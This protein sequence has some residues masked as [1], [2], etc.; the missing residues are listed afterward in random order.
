M[1]HII[2]FFVLII[3]CFPSLSTAS[4]FYVRDGGG[5]LY[6]ASQDPTGKCNGLTN[7]VYPGS[8]VN[9]NCA[10][11]NPDYVLGLGCDNF[12]TITNCTYGPKIAS[13][14][15]VFI[16]GDSDV[17]PGTQA[18]Y[19]IGW[20][21][22]STDFFN[23]NY[24]NCKSAYSYSCTM[25]NLP[26]GTSGAPTS[27]IGTGTHQ[28]QLYALNTPYQ[29]LNADNNF[30]TLQNLEI[31]DH[32]ACAYNDPTGSCSRYWD[33]IWLGGDSLIL[34]NIYAHG[35]SRY[36]IVTDNMG[37]ATF[38]NLWVIGNGYG[39]MTIGNGGTTS[40]SG[41]L[42]FNQP[43]VEWNGCV[44]A[45]PV[46]GGIDNPSNYT[47]CFGQTSGG[48]GDGLAFGP[49]GN[50]NAGNWTITGPGSISFN[51]QDGLDTLHG[52]GNGTIQVDKMRFEGNAGNQVK[53]NA[54]NES[55]TNSLV[56]GDCGWWFG[57]PQS[58]SGGMQS[59]DSCRALGDVFLFNVTN[60]SV[61]NIF[62]NT[63]MSNGNISLESKDEG[64]TGCNSNTTITAKN[65][66]VLGGYAWWDDTTWNGSGGNSFTTYIY[67][68]G[69]NGDG[70]G[71]CGGLTWNE[72]YNVVSWSAPQCVGSHD[73][74]NT[75]PGFTGTIPIG[76]SGGGASTYYQGQGAV[77]QVPITNSSAAK[78]AGVSGLSYWNN[79]NDYY[80]VTR[81]SPPSI[82][83]L[84]YASC[85]VNTFSPCFFN[86]DCCIGTCTN[87]VCA[88]A[89]PGVSEYSLISG[90]SLISGN[91]NF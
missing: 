21:P 49:S 24:G 1:W 58:L 13:G 80:N 6:N 57:A 77:T 7:A 25:A 84:E 91:S 15:T 78:G 65:N 82:G 47:N 62:N 52:A 17:N 76:T 29:V 8:G 61:T 31:T 37:S 86:T 10:V 5:D 90:K 85:A 19:P 41:T 14:D 2:S 56:I 73:K 46:T 63:F 72:D 40:I 79:S 12:G 32:T 34:T 16:S 4:V 45:Y 11:S 39:G 81:P 53:M 87:N 83:G 33:G 69:N 89:S 36:G 23:G 71:T 59:G 67:N 27:I 88:G 68:A 75:S 44:E 18:Q 3:T 22:S 38:T 55:L 50:Q 9:Q 28:P 43:I 64:S 70:G 35:L 54:I 26:A 51:T 74:C 48:Y 60:N 30:I 66:I 42:T 20:N